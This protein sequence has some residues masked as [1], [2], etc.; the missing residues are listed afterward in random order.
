M[1]WQECE[2]P[3]QAASNCQPVELRIVSRV[4][5]LGGFNVRRV[6]P[7]IQRQMVGPFIFWDQMGLARFAPGTG[8]D[9]RP[10]PHI[11]LATVTYLFGGE[12]MHRDSLGTVIP[13][14][15]GEMNLMTA[16]SG[17][18]HSERTPPGP[19]AAGHELY[20]IQAWVALP[21]SHEDGPPAFEHFSA[22]DLPTIEGRGVALRLIA[23]EM[24]GRVSPV[25]LPMGTIYAEARLEPGAS[26]PFDAL[27]EERAI[28]TC[29]GEIEIDGERF[30]PA[31]LLVLRAG[32]AATIRA[33]SSARLMLL[34]GEPADGPRFIWWNF[35]AST[36]ERIEQAKADWQA[37]RFASVPGET[38]SIPLPS[39]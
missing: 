8:V 4:R 9:V 32:H 1:S 10:H 12:I 19:R 37:G 30:G 6:L 33:V 3:E 34:G 38:E 21:R 26:L 7:A 27:Y 13:I 17:I 25:R 2:Q 28:Y 24:E 11:G 35:V 36:R 15:P 20:G 5:D 29:D 14:R 31:Q 16:G 22:A 23:G 18:V 39:R